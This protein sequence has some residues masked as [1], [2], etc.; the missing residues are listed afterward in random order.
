MKNK[1]KTNN[2]FSNLKLVD[3]YKEFPRMALVFA[4]NRCMINRKKLHT[5]E[6]VKKFFDES[7][8]IWADRHKLGGKLNDA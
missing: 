8:K 1:F 3:E 6:D 7:L 4:T 2:S 5:Q